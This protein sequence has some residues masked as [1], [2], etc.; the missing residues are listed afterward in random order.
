[1][2]KPLRSLL[3]ALLV[4]SVAFVADAKLARTG[5]PSVQFTGKGTVGTLIGK[6]SDLE[7]ADDGTTVTVSV[8]LGNLQT[9]IAL[10]DRHM[11]EKYLEVQKFPKA[12]LVVTRAALNIKPGADSAG[13]VQGTFT[14]HGV[15][16]P[17]TFNYKA[18]RKGEGYGVVGKFKINVLDFGIQK[19][20]YL[21]VGINPDMDVEVTFDATDK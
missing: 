13:D 10:R 16:K 8:P 9:G 14:L 1:M 3:P 12:E 21:G 15:S 17:V 19:P 7:I 5:V 2:M 6:G 4:L 11:R 20:S 18:T